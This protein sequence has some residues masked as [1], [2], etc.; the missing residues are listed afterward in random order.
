MLALF[1]FPSLL[2]QR[3]VC[4]LAKC[5]YG[6]LRKINFIFR[7][8]IPFRRQNEGLGQLIGNVNRFSS[9]FASRKILLRNF[10]YRGSIRVENTNDIRDFYVFVISRMKIHSTFSKLCCETLRFINTVGFKHVLTDM[11]EK[12]VN[13]LH[14]IHR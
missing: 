1:V 14:E 8:A 13:L 12:R 10:R 11:I 9:F 7:G 4:P 6:K 5:F 3:I 2:F